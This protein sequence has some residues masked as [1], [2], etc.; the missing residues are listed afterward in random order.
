MAR[1]LPKDLL[2]GENQH[3]LPGDSVL[4]MENA[5]PAKGP[6]MKTDDDSGS[7]LEIAN[8]ELTVVIRRL[9]RQ[10][11]TQNSQIQHYESLVASLQSEL[12]SYRADRN[13]ESSSDSTREISLES[14]V[15]L[16]CKR[17]DEYSKKEKLFQEPMRPLRD[18]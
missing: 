8:R 18:Q 3:R 5:T 1:S 2:R 12:R 15:K 14:Q 17:N 4:H 11:E 9:Q 7:A 6:E 16:F 13:E 10:A